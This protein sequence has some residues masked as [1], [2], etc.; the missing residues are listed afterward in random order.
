[1]FSN[2]H[3]FLPAPYSFSTLRSSITRSLKLVPPAASI[4]SLNIVNTWGCYFYLLFAARLLTGIHIFVLS[5]SLLHSQ[6]QHDYTWCF[7]TIGK[8]TS[9]VLHRSNMPAC[10][11][12]G[13][14]FDSQRR[15]K[16][17]H[18]SH[19][20]LGH[21]PWMLRVRIPVWQSFHYGNLR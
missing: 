19:R 12:W 4:L 13:P 15:Q 1:M 6:G 17:V 5:L 2:E 16:S 18:T 7:L 9:M 3:V 11:D 14:R 21:L 20:V 10:G 8:P